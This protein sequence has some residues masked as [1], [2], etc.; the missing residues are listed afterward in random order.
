MKWKLGLLTLGIVSVLCCKKE[1]LPNEMPNR[2]TVGG[3]L[4]YSSPASDGSGYTF[5]IDSTGEIIVS[6]DFDTR[7]YDEFINAH[8]RLDFVNTGRTRCISGFAGC[9]GKFRIVQVV[10]IKKD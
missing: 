9:T 4:Y 3:Y 2:A 8:T 5:R 7:Q 6:D 10:S 1:N